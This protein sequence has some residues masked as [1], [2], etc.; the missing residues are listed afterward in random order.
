M[1]RIES[2]ESPTTPAEPFDGE[3]VLQVQDGAAE[4][5]HAAQMLNFVPPA[6]QVMETV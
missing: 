3:G 6:W 1:W 4:V 5:V 2:P